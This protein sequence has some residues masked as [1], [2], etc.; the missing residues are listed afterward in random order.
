MGVYIH[1]MEMPRNCLACDWCA[2][3]IP[4]DNYICY[5]L[6]RAVIGVAKEDVN[7][8]VNACCPIVPAPEHGRLGDLDDF[9]KRMKNLVEKAEGDGFDLGAA[10]YSAFVRHIE[11]TP[12]I[13]EADRGDDQ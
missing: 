11:L 2:Y 9:A 1:N 4:A 13:I 7:E 8:T 3:T 5:R 12:T 6:N 10:W